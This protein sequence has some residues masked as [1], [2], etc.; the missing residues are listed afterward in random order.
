MKR[1]NN[2]FNEESTDKLDISEINRK[3][4]EQQYQEQEE[5]KK[6]KQKKERL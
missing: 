1:E 3:F 2:N 4:Y 5:E 6:E